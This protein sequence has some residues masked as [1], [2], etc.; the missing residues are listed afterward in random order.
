MNIE[1]LKYLMIS[2]VALV[3]LFG[4]VLVA[5][6][7]SYR[8]LLKKLY[9]MGAKEATIIEEARQ[10]AAEILSQTQLRAEQ[11]ISTAEG[12]TE[13]QQAKLQAGLIKLL[14]KQGQV[15]EKE[16]TGV[17]DETKHSLQ[18]AIDKQIK[19]MY[20]KEY[21]SAKQSIALYKK[22]KLAEADKVV[23]EIIQSAA[24]SVL[25][26]SIRLEDHTQ[27]IIKSLEEA[28]KEHVF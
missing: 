24:T 20:Q 1:A 14:D 11:L 27:E 28:K 25:R 23:Q 21:E 5:L 13:E 22:Q 19:E 15:A 10:Q 12:L 16:L 6:A 9:T 3:L 4:V 2:L 26:K 18:A 17:S 7:I 8:K